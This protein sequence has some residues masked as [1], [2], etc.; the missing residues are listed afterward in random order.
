MP[1]IRVFGFPVSVTKD[2]DDYTFSGRGLTGLG[3]TISD[4]C[5]KGPM[6]WAEDGSSF[7]INANNFVKDS[8]KTETLK[9]ALR[10]A[11][12]NIDR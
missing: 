5:V 3:M 8:I 1:S 4:F 6:Q 9:T 12:P 7:T 11:F 2:G 10:G